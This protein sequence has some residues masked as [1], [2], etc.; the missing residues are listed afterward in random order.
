[1]N[2]CNV[3]QSES[4]TLSSADSDYGSRTPLAITRSPKTLNRAFD[5]CIKGKNVVFAQGEFWLLRCSNKYFLIMGIIMKRREPSI[6]G[7]LCEHLSKPCFDIC[8]TV[9]ISWN[10]RLLI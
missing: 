3:R 9:L 5:R 4:F 10:F 6:L 7:R 8:Y 2:G 1:M